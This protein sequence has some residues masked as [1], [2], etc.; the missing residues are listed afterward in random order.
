MLLFFVQI[1]IFHFQFIFPTIL[2]NFRPPELG[3]CTGTLC[4]SDLRFPLMWKD[5]DHFRNRGDYR[6]YA[7]FALLRVGTEIYD[8]TLV[9]PVDRS[10]TDITFDDTV[11]L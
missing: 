11:I 5:L 4:L 9:N 1:N 7:V 3:G 2:Y 10:V 8:T 6:R